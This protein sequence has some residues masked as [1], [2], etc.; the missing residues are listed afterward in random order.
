MTCLQKIKERKQL[1]MNLAK[2]KKF[3]KKNRYEKRLAIVRNT[4]TFVHHHE[5]G[6]IGKGSYFWNPIFLSGTRYMYLGKKVGFWQH[7]RIEAID[8]WEEQHFSPKL[9]IGDHVNIGQNC[10]ITLAESIVIEKDVVCSARVTITDISHITD[11]VNI[12]VLN[13]GLMTKPVKICEGAFIGIN[14]V[15]LPGVTVGK[16][17]IV[18]AGSIVTKDVPD[19]ATVAGVPARVIRIRNDL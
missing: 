18:G 15:I 17:A 13:Q 2:I 9:T 1:S 4:Y 5:F 19:Y 3:F 10:H 11:N 8:E 6:Q 14:S 12:A 7:A 16:H